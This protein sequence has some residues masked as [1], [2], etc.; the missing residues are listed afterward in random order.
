MCVLVATLGFWV[1][2][3]K[4]GPFL[5][6]HKTAAVSHHQH[7]VFA[8]GAAN[9]SHGIA[10][11]LRYAA[12]CLPKTVCRACKD[13][14]SRVQ[15]FKIAGK[16]DKVL[17][18]RASLC[19]AIGI[20]SLR[21]LKASVAQPLAILPSD[22]ER[23]GSTASQCPRHTCTACDGQTP[24]RNKSGRR[25]AC[26]AGD[27]SSTKSVAA[28]I[29]CAN[30]LEFVRAGGARLTAAVQASCA[31]NPPMSRSIASGEKS[32]VCVPRIVAYTRYHSDP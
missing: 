28:Q 31:I 4:L 29:A 32:D 19:E 9:E 7:V 11:I 2:V 30:A 27:C 23:F 3:A 1:F 8:S 18:S 13:L 16:L 25:Y 26:S 14:T 6:S 24:S 21:H 5:L 10:P 12:V 15:L 22:I 17:S 20:A